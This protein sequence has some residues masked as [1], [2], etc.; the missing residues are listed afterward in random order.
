MKRLLT[1]SIILL[2]GCSASA[3]SKK[4]EER[5]HLVLNT[6][7]AS[8][9]SWRVFNAPFIDMGVEYRL[10]KLFSVSSALGR[11][12]RSPWNINRNE[13]KGYFIRSS[14]RIYP[15]R[16]NVFHPYVGLQLKHD[17]KRIDRTFDFSAAFWPYK[18]KAQERRN[19]N[20]IF[21]EIGAMN[22]LS[23]KRFTIDVNFALGL[24]LFTRDFVGLTEAETTAAESGGVQ[25][26]PTMEAK[27]VGMDY[28]ID[29][30][31]GYSI[32]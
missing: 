9:F 10:C 1:I 20:F 14:F 27:S 25:G 8:L 16:P 19:S 30:K 31:I 2:F 17:S 6:S 12:Y 23:G 4:Y 11:F 15:L 28:L 18:K 22:L 21:A 32:F 24:E 5:P 7:V 13:E 26:I 29:F 3:Q